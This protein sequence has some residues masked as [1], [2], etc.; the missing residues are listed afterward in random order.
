M[1]FLNYMSKNILYIGD[2]KILLIDK[3]FYYLSLKTNS[4]KLVG[5]N[6]IGLL[7]DESIFED[8]KKLDFYENVFPILSSLKNNFI[9]KCDEKIINLYKKNKKLSSSIENFLENHKMIIRQNKIKN[10]LNIIK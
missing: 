6:I 4:I 10:L 5:F 7:I 3:N 9:L 8:F 2:E 1:G